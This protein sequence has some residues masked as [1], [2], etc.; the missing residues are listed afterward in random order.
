MKTYENINKAI[1][2]FNEVEEFI[3]YIICHHVNPEK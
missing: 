3:N 1:Y 2:I